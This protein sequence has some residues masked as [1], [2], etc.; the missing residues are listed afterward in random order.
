MTGLLELSARVALA[1][2]GDRL[3]NRDIA[4][5]IGL[6]PD[7]TWERPISIPGV[8]KHMDEDCWIKNGRIRRALPY[9]DSLDAAMRLVPAGWSPLIDMTGAATTVVELYA[10]LP[11]GGLKDADALDYFERRNMN[12]QRADAAT[13]ALALTAAALKARALA[14][15]GAEG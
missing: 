14:A 2:G 13:P 8:M 4:E 9:T 11:P 1:A 15:Q 6:G 10:P 7:E 3:L 5:A 12:I